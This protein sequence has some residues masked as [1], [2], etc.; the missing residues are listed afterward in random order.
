MS[1]SPCRR[2]PRCTRRTDRA[3]SRSVGLWD[4]GR[5]AVHRV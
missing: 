2:W 4:R 3:R 1:G 5:C